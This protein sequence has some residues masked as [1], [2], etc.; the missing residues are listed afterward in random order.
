VLARAEQQDGA[1]LR[2]SHVFVEEDAVYLTAMPR[3][4]P[5]C[6]TLGS[7]QAPGMTPVYPPATVVALARAGIACA[8][9]SKFRAIERFY[10]EM[11]PPEPHLALSRRLWKLQSVE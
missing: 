8:I 9:R 2:V 5:A 1:F 11:Q 4:W 6:I 3:A 10:L 7:G